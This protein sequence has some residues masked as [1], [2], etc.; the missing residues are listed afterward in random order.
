MVGQELSSLRPGDF[1]EQVE[2]SFNRLFAFLATPIV[3]TIIGQRDR[4]L[5]AAFAKLAQTNG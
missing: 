4:V 1:W 3:N 2:S 5:R